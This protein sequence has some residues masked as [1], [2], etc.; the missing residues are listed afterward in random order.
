M[1]LD[2]AA[3]VCAA[4]LTPSPATLVAWA[5]PPCPVEVSFPFLDLDGDLCHGAGD[6]GDVGAQLLDPDVPFAPAAGNLVCPRGAVLNGVVSGA[7]AF[8]RVSFEWVVPGTVVLDCKI[9]LK[10][11]GSA[12]AELDVEAGA[13]LRVGGSIT[14]EAP[15][16]LA[17][18]S[19]NLVVG[20][21]AKL[22]STAQDVLLSA[23]G[24]L[25][26]HARASAKTAENVEASAGGTL[27][28][29]ERAKLV[30]KNDGSIVLDGADVVVGDKVVLQAGRRQFGNG[31][32]SIAADPVSGAIVAGRVKLE[33]EAPTITA[34]T[35]TF[36]AGSVLQIRDSGTG[37][38]ITAE[39]AITMDGVRTKNEGVALRLT[40]HTAGTISLRDALLTGDGDHVLR[41]APGG[42]CDVTGTRTK[43]FVD[44][45]FEDCTP[46]G[47]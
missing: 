10:A 5:G 15:V 24:D 23:G 47:P 14:A 12:Q 43:G 25:D 9:R 39:T 19:G 30:S 13:D 21:K 45:E 2:V 36:G 6:S 40:V 32:V 33:G 34:G 31:T 4:L 17:A 41:T 22:S 1:R 42:V 37:T 7:P 8:A 11:G 28:L 20:E 29:G 38:A 46:V 16:S 35:I 27:A 44:L 26:I 3:L 18:P